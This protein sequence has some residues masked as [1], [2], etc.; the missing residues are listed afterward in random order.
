[1]RGGPGSPPAHF[2]EVLGQRTAL[3]AACSL[4]LV[5]LTPLR[6]EQ[7]L[8]RM[9]C[10]SKAQKSL[11]VSHT[12]IIL[13]PFPVQFELSVTPRRAQEGSHGSSHYHRF[14]WSPSGALESRQALTSAGRRLTLGVCAFCQCWGELGWGALL[15]L[16]FPEWGKKAEPARG[17]APV[18][19]GGH[20][21]VPGVSVGQ[22]YMVLDQ[23]KKWS[24]VFVHP[25]WDITSH[26]LFLHSSAEIL[27]FV[28]VFFKDF[29]ILS[30]CSFWK[31][32]P[33]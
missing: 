3:R 21:S 20:F 5:P 8:P 27:V 12:W 6:S 33:I 32:G 1:M 31:A 17:V 9:M 15:S 4:L 16:V 7:Y 26:L 18:S 10:P 30:H 14:S 24:D 2:Q 25:L 19:S 29:F 11:N 22:I 28:P 13:A 23:I